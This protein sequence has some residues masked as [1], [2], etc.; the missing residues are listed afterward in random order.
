MGVGSGRP[1]VPGDVG[2][3]VT[4]GLGGLLARGLP[5]LWATDMVRVAW[6]VSQSAFALPL[7]GASRI[8]AR[9]FYPTRKSCSFF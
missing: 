6:G 3:G 8:L 7:S 5:R 2:R 9:S 4:A 1:G